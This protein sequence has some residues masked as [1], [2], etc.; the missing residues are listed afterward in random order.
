MTY[1]NHA[2]TSWPK[3]APVRRAVAEALDSSPSDWSASFER[4]HRTVTRFLGIPDPGRLLL[5][6]GCTSA[7]A[8]AIGAVPWEAGDRVVVSHLEHHALYGPVQRLRE[9]GVEGVVVPRG[10]STPLDLDALRDA[11]RGGRVRLVAMT[12][13]CNV[14]GECLP[15]EEIVAAAHEHGALCLIDGAQAVGWLPLDLAALEVD[16][17]AFAGHKGLQAPWGIGGLVVAPNV[18]LATVSAACELPRDGGAPACAPMPGYC[19]GGSVDRAALAGLAAGIEWLEHPDRADRLM[20]ARALVDTVARELE[21]CPAIRLHGAASGERL[22]TLAL[23]L[24]GRPSGDV[25]A[26]LAR[27]GITVGSGLQCAPLAHEA[28]GTSSTGAVRIS[29]GPA[30]GEGEVEGLLAAFREL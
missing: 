28:L 19:D 11:L 5:T 23:T 2:G 6:P 20:R 21:A 12:A 27:R 10:E 3:P 15:I 26:D 29:V 8:L 14:T 17:F 9:R 7:L 25:A 30:T 16:L 1:L 22:P 4:A 18:S 13:A 24:E